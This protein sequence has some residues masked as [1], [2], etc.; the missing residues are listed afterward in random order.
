MVR[1]IIGLQGN[2]KIPIRFHCRNQLLMLKTLKIVIVWVRTWS[3]DTVE[4]SPNYIC[5]PRNGKKVMGLIKFPIYDRAI[6]QLFPHK[7]AMVCPNTS[8]LP[9]LGVISGTKLLVLPKC[10]L[11]GRHR[12]YRTPEAE[13]SHAKML[14]LKQWTRLPIQQLT[15]FTRH[16]SH[17][18]K[19]VH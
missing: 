16:S 2:T 7:I 1:I 8:G 9:W 5:A 17:P 15:E 11:A 4:H 6:R 3:F 10:C 13:P 18:K 19:W 14:A 12:I